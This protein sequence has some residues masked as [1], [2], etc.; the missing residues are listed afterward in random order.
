MSKTVIIY[1][2][3]TTE[4]SNP[5]VLFSGGTGATY[6]IEMT[7][8]GLLKF[9]QEADRGVVD[10]IDRGSVQY[11]STLEYKPN[12]DYLYMVYSQHPSPFTYHFD[13][14]DNNLSSG[15]TDLY[16]G[17][18]I[19][20]VDSA[21]NSAFNAP[22]NIMY[23]TGDDDSNVGT[24]EILRRVDVGTEQVTHEYQV[25][26]TGHIQSRPIQVN[27]DGTDMIVFSELAGTNYITD[28]YITF[29]DASDLSLIGRAHY[30]TTPN[31]GSVTFIRSLNYDPVNEKI[32]W[33]RKKPGSPAY[34]DNQQTYFGTYDMATSGFTT[35]STIGSIFNNQ[36]VLLDGTQK[37]YTAGYNSTTGTGSLYV[38]GGTFGYY[39][40]SNNTYTEL[41][42]KTYSTNDIGGSDQWTRMG[43]ITSDSRTNNIY[44]VFAYDLIEVN[45][46]DGSINE[47]TFLGDSSDYNSNKPLVTAI[48]IHQDRDEIWTARWNNPDNTYFV[49]YGL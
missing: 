47:T 31:G 37:L 23:L 43:H 5:H 41:T 27:Y 20:Q 39:D 17:M 28:T 6:T 7:T 3:G 42:G 32:Y 22:S 40:F 49:V 29:L 24:P 34:I 16:S 2:S 4:N 1:P 35:G 14:L 48:A 30:D 46:S 12:N 19:F 10:S 8:D 33:T 18:T 36:N 44:Q 9:C 15:S 25:V 45:G 26:S 13:Y 38:T 21:F 11:I